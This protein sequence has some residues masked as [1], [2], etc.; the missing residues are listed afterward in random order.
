M[1]VS[2]AVGVR[3]SRSPRTT[4]LLA[5]VL[6]VGATATQ[7]TAQPMPPSRPSARELQSSP[8]PSPQKPVAAP[9]AASAHEER[10]ERGECLAML[11]DA[12]WEAAPANP[13]AANVACSVEEPV[14]LNRLR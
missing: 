10:P 6:T 8:P 12:G 2:P 9:L 7:A 14:V 4:R 5:I 11:R 3:P 13:T 1:R